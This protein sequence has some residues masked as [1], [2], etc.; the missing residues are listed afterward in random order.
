VTLNRN[1]YAHRAEHHMRTYL[2]ARYHRIDD[3][4]TYF[5]GLGEEIAAQVHTLE[6]A[7]ARSEPAVTD[8][9]VRAGQLQAARM[10][11][12][13]IVFSDLVYLPPETPDPDDPEVTTD[14]TGAYYGWTD[15]TKQAIW[16]PEPEAEDW[17]LMAY[18]AGTDPTTGQPLFPDRHIEAQTA[19]PTRHPASGT[20]PE[21]TPGR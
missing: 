18:Y 21:A 3:P 14:Q 20:E 10:Q 5:T 4:E 19:H 6:I 12:E 17:A 11:A 15:L 9:L 16:A 1:R 2:P 7:L 8:Q 13:E